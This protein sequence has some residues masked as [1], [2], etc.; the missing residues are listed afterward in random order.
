MNKRIPKSIPNGRT[1]YARSIQK[2]ETPKPDP[3]IIMIPGPSLG[4]RCYEAADLCVGTP[5]TA[6]TPLQARIAWKISTQ[7]GILYRK[8]DLVNVCDNYDDRQ[9]LYR[10]QY[11]KKDRRTLICRYLMLSVVYRNRDLLYLILSFII[12]E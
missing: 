11:Y 1:N 10:E 12:D 7:T 4:S 2:E 5:E 6:Y 3:R 9:L 8:E